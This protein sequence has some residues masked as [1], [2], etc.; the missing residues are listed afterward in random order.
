[1]FISWLVEQIEER[2]FGLLTSTCA[3]CS[4][5]LCLFLLPP[6]PGAPVYLASGL[7]LTKVAE[8]ALGSYVM[9][10]VYAML[11]GLV[12]KLCACAIQQK[13]AAR[14]KREFETRR[15]LR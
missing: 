12:V 3:L 1:M 5:G 11:I 9:G 13:A 4:I 6:V 8:K 14:P 15:C 10:I 2:G 7:L